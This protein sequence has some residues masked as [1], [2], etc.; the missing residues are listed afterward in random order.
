VNSLV[1]DELKFRTALLLEISTTPI[2]LARVRE[3][4]A[5][6]R[7]LSTCGGQV[8]ERQPRRGDHPPALVLR[9][10]LPWGAVSLARTII[11][12]MGKRLMIQMEKFR[13]LFR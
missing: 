1:L 10:L 4:V 11:Q 3:V 8:Y 9:S 13:E 7:L 2:R 12:S 6:W 5:I